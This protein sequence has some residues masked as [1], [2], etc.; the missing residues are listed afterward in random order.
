M[1]APTPAKRLH[2]FA[3]KH[4]L[5]IQEYSPGLRVWSIRPADCLAGWTEPLAFGVPESQLREKIV[6]LA[7]ATAEAKAALQADGYSESDVDAIFHL[8]GDPA[9]DPCKWRFAFEAQLAGQVND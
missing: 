3:A 1:K 2:A 7:A 8:H 6:Q 4:G 5:S 9:I